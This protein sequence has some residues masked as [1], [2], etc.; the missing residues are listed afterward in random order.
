M[1]ATGEKPG[2]GVYVCINCGLMIT[3]EDDAEK[4]PPCPHCTGNGDAQ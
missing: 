2:T 1:P 3:L 4:L